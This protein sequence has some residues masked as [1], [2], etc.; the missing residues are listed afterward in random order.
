M[1][2]KV[3]KVIDKFFELNSSP[4]ISFTTEWI[5]HKAVL[6]G[7]LIGLAASRNKAIQQHLLSLTR[8]LDQLHPT[9]ALRI[10]FLVLCQSLKGFDIV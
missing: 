1:E 2:A 4:E 6:R 5:A 8:E 3:S 9:E 7:K 10:R